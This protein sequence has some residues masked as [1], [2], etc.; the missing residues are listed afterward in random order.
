MANCSGSDARQCKNIKISK[1]SEPNTNID[2]HLEYHDAMAM[3][4][5][6]LCCDFITSGDCKRR[7]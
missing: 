6:G 4:G 7:G 5:S 1:T 2:E 3:D